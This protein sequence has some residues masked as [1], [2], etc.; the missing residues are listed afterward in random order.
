VLIRPVPQA[1]LSAPNREEEAVVAMW[2]RRAELESFAADIEIASL[3]QW[4]FLAGHGLT[5]IGST[6]PNSAVQAAANSATA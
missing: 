4:P 2:E 5:A 1:S 3:Y 6:R